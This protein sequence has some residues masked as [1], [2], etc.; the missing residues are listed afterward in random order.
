LK[1]INNLFD[2]SKGL[3]S[4]GENKFRILAEPNLTKQYEKKYEF[5][6]SNV[7]FSSKFKMP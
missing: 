1:C 5:P 4:G 6:T 7:G 3:N 2:P